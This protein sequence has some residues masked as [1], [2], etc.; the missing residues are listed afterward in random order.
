MAALREVIV[1]IYLYHRYQVDAAAKL[2]GGFEFSYNLKGDTL[3][4]GR[5][6]ADETQRRALA[7]LVE[8]LDPAAL[9]LP[10]NLLNQLTPALGAFGAFGN[11]GEVFEGDTGP[12]FDMMSAADSAA[13]ITLK[14]VMHPDRA[15]RLI[16]YQRRNPNA[17]GFDDVLTAVENKLFA[18]PLNAN[19]REILHTEQTR[20][21]S[22][23][24]S[25]SVGAPAT[26]VAQASAVGLSS[27]GGQVATPAVQAAAEAELRAIRARLE[28]RIFGGASP[29][30]D[31][32]AWLSARIDAHLSRPAAPVFVRSPEPDIP[33]GSPIGAGMMEDCWHCEPTGE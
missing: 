22:A 16:E 25:L 10:D 14:A 23:L 28:P 30:R 27:G 32:N 20:F 9:S 7:A 6:V 21:V 4:G 19:Q 24:I 2:V 13:T 15:A 3:P 8:T 26:G 11:M 29:S 18:E 17:L 12:V 31:H 33:P 5:P 1:P